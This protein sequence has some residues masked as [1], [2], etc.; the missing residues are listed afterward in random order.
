MHKLID[1]HKEFQTLRD[2]LPKDKLKLYIPCPIGTKYWFVVR[3][4]RGHCIKILHS[5]CI[6]VLLLFL[7]ILFVSGVE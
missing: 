2:T 7:Y 6:H 5:H 4:L 3:S 1:Y